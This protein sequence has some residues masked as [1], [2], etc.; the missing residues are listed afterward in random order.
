MSA[1]IGCPALQGM[2]PV[3]A[4]ETRPERDCLPNL[5]HLL[6]DE[7][8]EQAADLGANSGAA[9]EPFRRHPFQHFIERRPAA[10][11]ALDR[12][13]QLVFERLWI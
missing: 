4:S 1:H 5:L 12:L 7:I 6:R 9:F 8:E 10:S 3:C 11:Q 13:D 2:D